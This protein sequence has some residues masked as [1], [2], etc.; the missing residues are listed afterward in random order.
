MAFKLD[1]GSVNRVLGNIEKAGEK[2]GSQAEAALFLEAQEILTR[3]RRDFVPVDLGILRA[4]SDVTNP[5]RSKNG[6]QVTIWYGAGPARKYAVPQHERL[7][8]KHKVGGPKYLE[9]PLLEAAGDLDRRLARR[10]K[11]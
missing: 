1:T 7:D 8:F 2:L 10:I 5:R 3:S 4:D 6:S 11:L 9:R